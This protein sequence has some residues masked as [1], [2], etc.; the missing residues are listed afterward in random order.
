MGV[1]CWLCMQNNKWENMGHQLQTQSPIELKG[2]LQYVY[3]CLV[4]KESKPQMYS[5]KQYQL[6][7]DKHGFDAN[8]SRLVMAIALHQRVLSQNLQINVLNLLLT[9]FVCVNDFKMRHT[10][11]E[12]RASKILPQFL[13][14]G[15]PC[16]LTVTHK[17][18]TL[19]L[20]LDI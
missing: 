8:N 19:N 6:L 15:L 3:L 10:Y 1:R 9:Y 5:E 14:Y 16:N 20:V 13:S 17:Y 4:R 7:N 2:Y 11:Q 18:D 12:H